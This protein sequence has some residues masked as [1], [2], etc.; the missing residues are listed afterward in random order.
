MR[1]VN[2]TRGTT[3][4]TRAR[5]ASGFLERLRGLMFSPGL[6]EEGGLLLEPEGSI[7]TFFMR[8]PLDVAYLDG[9]YR[10]LRVCAHMAPNRP[11]PVT[12]RGCRAVL[13]LPPGTLAASGTEPGDLLATEE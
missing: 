6:P 2:L 9:S 8:F 10:V 12:T 1:I 13:E 7:H 11:G 4:A 3:V 5:R